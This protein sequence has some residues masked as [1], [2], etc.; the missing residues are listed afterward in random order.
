MDCDQNWMGDRTLWAIVKR[1][2]DGEC[3]TLGCGERSDFSSQCR[4]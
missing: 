2:F 4:S 3:V 1:I